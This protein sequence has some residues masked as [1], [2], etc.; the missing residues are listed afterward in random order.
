MWEFKEENLKEQILPNMA[1]KESGCYKTKI[2]RAELWNSEKNKS[3]AL[4]LTFE[5]LE[6]YKRARVAFYYENKN[7]ENNEFI[8]KKLN[9]LEYLVNVHR[10]HLGI[11][12]DEE[13][14]TLIKAYEN[15]KIGLFLLYRGVREVVNNETG[16][17]KHFDDYDVKGF[18][19]I[20]TL[21][22]TA[23]LTGELGL[24]DSVY[25][26]WKRN[27][28]VINKINEKKETEKEDTVVENIKDE[29]EVDENFPF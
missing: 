2:I 16:E 5:D 7:G 18:F 1:I 29:T 22:T 12:K 10:D 8:T 20:E 25:N 14:K 26:I 21:L 28:E 11:V 19:D 9:Q 4:V 6:T 23:E 13:G 17:V 24:E 27:F 15:K 3:R